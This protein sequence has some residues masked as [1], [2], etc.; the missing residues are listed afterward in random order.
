MLSPTEL[1]IRAADLAEAEGR[2]LRR[3]TVR[4]AAS[5]GLV[6]AAAL[7]GVGGFGLVLASVYL[8]VASS[9]GAAAGAA[10][11]GAVALGVGGLLAWL[12][13]RVTR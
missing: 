10:V 4:V 8:L 11:A 12:A 2:V 13:G 9:F 6:L 3:M 7:T 5:F 1:L